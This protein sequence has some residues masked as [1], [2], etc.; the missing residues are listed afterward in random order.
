MKSSLP[1]IWESLK[2]PD[3]DE[4]EISLFGPGVGE[5]VVVHLG[6]G[7]W[8]VVD[9][10]YPVGGAEPVALSYLS[11]LGLGIAAGNA[12]RLVVATHWHADH[13]RGM[14]RLLEACPQAEFICSVSTPSPPDLWPTQSGLVAWIQRVSPTERSRRPRWLMAR[15]PWT[16]YPQPRRL[17]PGW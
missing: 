2:P 6:H 10:C 13:I 1:F 12:V 3:K 5:C 7:Q 16:S 9:S 15:L 11:A 17:P 8:M 4:F 14:A